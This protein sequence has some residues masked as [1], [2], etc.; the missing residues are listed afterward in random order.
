VGIEQISLRIRRAETPFYR[1]V[2]RLARS[3]LTFRLPVPAPW[4]WLMVG[5]NGTLRFCELAWMRIQVSLYAEPLLRRRCESVGNN[6]YMER[7]PS[8]SGHLRLRL[9]D[10]VTLSGALGVSCSRVCESPELVIGNRVFLGHGVILHPN[11]QILIEDDV[12]IAS[13]C[14]ITD[15]NEHPIDMESRIRGEACGPDE[16][17]PVRIRRGAWLGKNCI[18]LRGVEIGEGAIVGAGSVVSK[19]VPPFTIVSGNPALVVR[20]LPKVASN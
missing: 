6:L 9:G 3:V 20:D 1:R 8:I 7:L 5:L 2:K 13:G 10:N 12:L 16:I 19:S 18:V 15:S 11:R 4:V 14:F 17:R